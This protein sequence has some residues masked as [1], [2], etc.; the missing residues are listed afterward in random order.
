MDEVEA[1]IESEQTTK[2]SN[3]NNDNEDSEW[4]DF[5]DKPCLPPVIKEMADIDIELEEE[6]KRSSAEPI[7]TW[8]FVNNEVFN[9]QFYYK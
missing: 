1:K 8:N 5:D 7:K 3:N 6:E 4:L 2:I 9:L